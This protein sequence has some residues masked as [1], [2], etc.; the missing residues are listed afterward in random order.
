M[1][2][3]PLICRMA[4]FLSKNKI[5]IKEDVLKRGKVHRH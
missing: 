3:H 2:S 5:K 1:R 4:F